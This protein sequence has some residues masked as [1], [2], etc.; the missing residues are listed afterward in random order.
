MAFPEHANIDRQMRRKVRSVERAYNDVANRWGGRFGERVWKRALRN[1][2]AD[3]IRSARLATPTRTG[4]LRRR[5]DVRPGSRRDRREA[6]FA[7]DFGFYG[8]R[9][10]QKALAVEFGNRNVAEH[11]VL[12]DA[13]ARHQA[14]AVQ[15]ISRALAAEIDTIAEELANKLAVDNRRG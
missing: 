8:P 7:I 4:R 14:R 11:S 6:F 10:Y 1:A 3:M 13:F 15:D 12:R 9:P 5:L 2:F